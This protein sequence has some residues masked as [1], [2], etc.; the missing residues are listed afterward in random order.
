MRPAVRRLLAAAFLAVAVALPAAG[1]AQETPSPSSSLTIAG[2]QLAP[3][4]RMTPVGAFP[5]GGALTPD[6]RFYWSADGG[7]GSTAVRIVDVST[8]AVKQVL[9]IPGGYVG[10]A[11]AP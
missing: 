7:R 5:T 11:F 8:G 9:P 10:I 2:R 1:V 4:G 3:A 6:G